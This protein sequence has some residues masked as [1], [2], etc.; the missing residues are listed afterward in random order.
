MRVIRDLINLKPEDAERGCVATIGNFDGVHVGHQAII[1]GL[2]KEAIERELPAAVISFEPTPREY[3]APETAPPRLTGFR[4]K[5]DM[6]ESHGI[7]KLLLLRFDAQRAKQEAGEFIREVLV[8]GLGVKY[9]LVGDDFRFGRD[10]AGDFEMLRAAGEKY[11]FEVAA[12]PTQTL[13]GERVSSTRVRE[14][15][16]NDEL[17]LAAELLGRMYRISGKVAHGDKLGRTID[18]PTANIRRRFEKLPLRGVYLVRTYGLGGR[19]LYGAA[20]VGTRPT[21]DGRKNLVEVHLFDHDKDI[22]GERIEVEFLEKLRDEK[23]FANIEALKAQIREDVNEA[24]LRR[25][26][27]QKRE[28]AI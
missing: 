19:P 10:R 6:L 4:E 13:G 16:T 8:E 7:D 15:L 22:Y 21:V 18:F 9:L 17:G 1:S 27:W 28:Q 2:R 3:F 20:N 26:E 25:T 12:T 5:F 14:A 24:M 23:K 11:G